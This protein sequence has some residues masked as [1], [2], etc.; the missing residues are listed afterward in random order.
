MFP[1]EVL[2]TCGQCLEADTVGSQPITG[3][4]KNKFR[5]GEMA[6]QV[7]THAAKPDNLGSIPEILLAPG[8]N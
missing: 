1:R 4:G 3:S 6:L 2:C 8:K 7:K 5:A